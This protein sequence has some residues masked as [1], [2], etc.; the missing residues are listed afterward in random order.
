[1]A[2]VFDAATDGGE[3]G[4]EEIT[5]NHTM[6]ASA[7]GVVF[8]FLIFRTA[9]SA[10]TGVGITWDGGAMTAIDDNVQAV[11]GASGVYAFEKIAPSTGAKNCIASWTNAIN[12]V[13]AVVSFTGANQSNPS[14][15]VTKGSGNDTTPTVDVSSAAA[16]IA[17]D[18][19]QANYVGGDTLTVGAD[20][21]QRTT[22]TETNIFGA[23]STEPGA[24]TNTM[25]WTLNN[26]RY[27]RNLAFPVLPS[28][29]AGQVIFWT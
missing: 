24:A 23:T 18:A 16:Q 1:M 7:N 19:V 5:V 4:V 29:S 13:L 15:T 12:A 21:T 26:T 11:V 25:S 10:P 22:E 28:T 8:A 3:A 17:L 2:V 20:Q 27:W 14:G 9:G 6:S